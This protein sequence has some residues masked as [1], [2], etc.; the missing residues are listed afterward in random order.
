MELHALDRAD[1]PTSLRLS[2]EGKALDYLILILKTLFLTLI[3]AGLYYPW[4]RARRLQFLFQNTRLGQHS[5]TFT[6][7]GREIALSYL[8]GIAL[9]A[10]FYGL[11]FGTTKISDSTTWLKLVLVW[12]SVM[13]FYSILPLAIWGSHAYRLSRLRYRSI[14]FSMDRIRRKAF[15]LQFLLDMIFTL[16]SFGFY[17]PMLKF[18]MTE[19][20][21]SS[22][23]WGDQ[24][25]T[26]T[27]RSRDSY[28]LALKNFGLCL[29]T[30]GLYLPF[31]IASRV[32]FTVAHTQFGDELDFAIDLKAKDVLTLFL[33]PMIL[34]TLTLGLAYPWAYVWQKQRLYLKVLFFGRL[35]LERVQQSKD[36]AAAA[37]GLGDFLGVDLSLGV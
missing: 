35:P 5:L 24:A 22:A 36:K 23:R 29:I 6:G 33:W 30:I 10:I 18:H 17:F 11:I 25:F 14:Y 9:Y 7:H 31:A 16:L 20:L 19:A 12:I 13:G 4:A 26:F 34:S 28:V 8:K 15:V 37:E 27:A 2:F 1:Q 32:R 3:T 21:I